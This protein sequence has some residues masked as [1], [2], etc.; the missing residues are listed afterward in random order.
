M[1]RPERSELAALSAVATTG[2]LGVLEAGALGFSGSG[3]AILHFRDAD[4]KE[5]IDDTIPKLDD[6]K[7]QFGHYP[8]SLSEVT[9][10]NLPYYLKDRGGYSSNGTQFAFYYEP[11]DSVISGLMLTDTHRRWMRAD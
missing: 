1:E 7:T 8:S 5:F 4:L 3:P 9:K 11:P 6:Y 2:V 10:K